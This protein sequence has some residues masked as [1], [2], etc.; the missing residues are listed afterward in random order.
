[1]VRNLFVTI[2]IGFCFAT[3][4]AAQQSR[5]PPENQ[6]PHSA[7]P[8]PNDKRGTDENPITV[9]IIPSP[10]TESEAA[11][12][13]SDREEKN[14]ADQWMVKLTGGLVAVGLAQLAVFVLQLVVFGLQAKRLRETVEKMDE[15]ADGQTR[16]MQSSIAQATRSAEAMERVA[17]SL[18]ANAESVK[19]SVQTTKDIADRQKL[20]GELQSRA[21]L[22]VVFGEMITQQPPLRFEPKLLIINNGLTPASKVSFRIAADVMPFPL[23]DDFGF[24][25]PGVHPQASI[26]IIG[27]RLNKIISAVVPKLYPDIEAHQ[28]M[29]G[30][31]QRIYVWGE[32]TYEDAFGIPRWVK[33]SQSFFW[34]NA[35]RVMSIDTRRH[36][37]AN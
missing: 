19:I 37:D 22:S 32:V 8:A 18:A 1:L 33:F 36:N 13:K 7:Q 34:L 25:L 11:Q 16:D 2:A 35:E 9:K 20:I 29:T 4:A 31:G 28:I 10:K 3:P 5:K 6:P 27:P 15:V 21:Y 23:A 26:G 30:V 17:E 12:E 14:S 24:P